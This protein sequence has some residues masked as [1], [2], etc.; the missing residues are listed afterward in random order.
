[1]VDSTPDIGRI[2]FV[3]DRDGDLFKSGLPAALRLPTP[4]ETP[5][6]GPHR[7]LDSPIP[8]IDQTFLHRRAAAPVVE[9]E[10]DTAATVGLLVGSWMLGGFL[11]SAG[12]ALAAALVGLWLWWA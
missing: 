2:R 5:T 1:M 10:V 8:A 12:T 3:A 11:A 4:D 7:R 9:A 6:Y